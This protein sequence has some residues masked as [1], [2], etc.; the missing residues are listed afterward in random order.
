MKRIIFLLFT[1]CI[2]CCA[3]LM[4]QTRIT[5]NKTAHNFGQVQWKQ[6]VSVDYVITNSGDK[7]LVLTNITTSCACAV[8]DW[9]KTPI[10]PGEKGKI[11]ATFDAK[12]L[13]RF[14]KSVC[15]Y[16]NAV[17]E[18]LYLHFSGEVVQKVTNF[19]NMDLHPFG[20]ILLDK[21]EIDFPDSHLG[22]TPGLT[23]TIVNQSE[24]PYE[25][26]LMHLPSY[27]TMQAEPA[28]LQKGEKGMIKLTLHTDRLSGLGLTQTSVYLS[29]FGGDKVSDDNEIP[30]S[31][32]LLPDFSG[33]SN[34]QRLN[35]PSIQLSEKDIDLS[36][37]LSKKSKARYDITIS[38][39][40][41]SQLEI[42][43]LQ[44]FNPAVGVDLKTSIIQ[45]DGKTRLRITL[46]KKDLHKKKHLRILMITNDPKQPKVTINIQASA[47]K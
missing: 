41:K 46:N 40:G 28:V 19:T 17:P 31:A 34:A 36:A 8:A 5:S 1:L 7:P 24:M 33:I 26:V 21:T 3:S 35:A 38:N 47:N 20:D 13:G 9:T 45:P 16:S 10:M 14:K 23:M 44:V 29:R 25:P 22:D 6:P 42:S 12:A 15:I 4:A 11:T 2:V 43:K 18:L 30:L 27:I 39:T 37:Q 32:V